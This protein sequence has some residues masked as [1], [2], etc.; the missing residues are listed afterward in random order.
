VARFATRGSRGQPVANPRVMFGLRGSRIGRYVPWTSAL[1]L[2]IWFQPAIEN[3]S[4]RASGELACSPK[5]GRTSLY[6]PLY[7]LSQNAASAIHPPPDPV[8]E[9]ARSANPLTPI[10]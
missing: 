4:L 8:P 2:A 6:E 7:R 9:A 10:A 5:V 1:S 3:S